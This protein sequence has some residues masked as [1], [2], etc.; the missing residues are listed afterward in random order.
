MQ[1]Y[2]NI[3][4]DGLQAT[5]PDAYQKLQA[6]GAFEESFYRAPHIKVEEWKLKNN[7]LSPQEQVA[8]I[9]SELR[10]LRARYTDADLEN[11][12]ELKQRLSNLSTL[13]LQIESGSDTPI[14]VQ[15]K[16]DL[17]DLTF[18]QRWTLN[19]K[20]A[21]SKFLQQFSKILEKRRFK[22][23]SNFDEFQKEKEEYLL[24]VVKEYLQS[25]SMASA[26]S[27]LTR[28]KLNYIPVLGGLNKRDLYKFM[29]R[30]Q[31]TDTMKGWYA[32]LKDTY[33]DTNL[34]VEVELT[35]AQKQFRN[36]YHKVKNE[37]YERVVNTSVEDRNGKAS[38]LANVQG[39]DSQ[40]YKEFMPR[41]RAS[42]SELL[43]REKLSGIPQKV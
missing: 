18:I 36:W 3:I 2:L 12:P 4:R 41:A 31:E 7:K 20:D 23:N 9:D 22:F 40:L 35:D 11:R 13:R 8:K 14:D 30:Y 5:N 37:T 39:I 17:T 15:E 21:P 43:E 34:G 42:N 25:N 38:T 6:K 26:L 1:P 32:N 28:D 10:S 27:F 16:N 33:F 29:W 24:P 19:I